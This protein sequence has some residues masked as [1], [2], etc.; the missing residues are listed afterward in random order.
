[1]AY[2]L[3]FFKIFVFI[4]ILKYSKQLDIIFIYQSEN[5]YPRGRADQA[6]TYY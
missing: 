6:P 1:M 5:K 2:K 3:I 4:N